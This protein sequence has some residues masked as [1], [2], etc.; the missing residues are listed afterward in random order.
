MIE[1]V[2]SGERTL[3]KDTVL[4][5]AF[6]PYFPPGTFLDKWEIYYNHIGP[7]PPPLGSLVLTSF[8]YLV[9]IGSSV[10]WKEVL[11]QVVGD[12]TLQDLEFLQVGMLVW[13]EHGFL[14]KSL[15]QMKG[16]IL[17]LVIPYTL[18]YCEICFI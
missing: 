9:Y 17:Y 13:M 12:S 14:V 11:S 1:I 10:V 16:L 3:Q 15:L 6:P 5:G 2:Q 7:P 18:S 8:A 4:T